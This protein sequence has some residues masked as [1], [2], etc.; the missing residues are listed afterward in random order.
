MLS[1]R[2]LLLE[3]WLV[4]VEVLRHDIIDKRKSSA[5]VLSRPVTEELVQQTLISACITQCIQSGQT[6][7]TINF[8]L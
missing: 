4:G 6:Q 1:G 3:R 5:D 8:C 7:L 2:C